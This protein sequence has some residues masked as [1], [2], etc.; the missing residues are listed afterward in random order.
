MKT[1][2]NHQIIFHKK[3]WT[4]MIWWTFLWD[5]LLDFAK[6]T[7]FVHSVSYGL[8]RICVHLW[9]ETKATNMS[10]GV[11]KFNPCIWFTNKS[12]PFSV[13]ILLKLAEGM[14]KKQTISTTSPTLD[15]LNF[16]PTWQRIRGTTL[17]IVSSWG[18]VSEGK[19][20]KC[21]LKKYLDPQVL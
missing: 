15:L 8:W 3:M 11:L 6:K 5:W 2:K 9:S 18:M 19:R 16:A 7:D 10:L 14:G 17:L 21:L 1:G 20:A 13:A 4:T 12:W